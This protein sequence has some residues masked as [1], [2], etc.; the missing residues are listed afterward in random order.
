MRSL[1]VKRKRG[2]VL[3][4]VGVINV[5]KRSFHFLPESQKRFGHGTEKARGWEKRKMLDGL[6]S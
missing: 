6:L 1:S 2:W 4:R 5:R 3:V